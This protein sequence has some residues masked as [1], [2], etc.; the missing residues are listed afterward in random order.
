MI[1]SDLLKLFC[2]LHPKKNPTEG[3]DAGK[4]KAGFVAEYGNYT[5]VSVRQPRSADMLRI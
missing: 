5:K 2:I 1:L 4:G 3:K